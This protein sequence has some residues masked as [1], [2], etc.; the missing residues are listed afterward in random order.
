M[1]P[2]PSIATFTFNTRL[3]PKFSYKAQLSP[4]PA[5]LKD[6]E[7]KWACNVLKTPYGSLP[8][9]LV[10]YG[11]NM[12]FI[13]FLLLEFNLL[14][15]PLGLLGLLFKI[16]NFGMIFF[17]KKF[18][19]FLPCTCLPLHMTFSRLPSGILPPLL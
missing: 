18:L 7:L 5:S 12:D 8:P 17:L 9:S 2:P 19:F 14:L 4:P 15:L 3:V 13:N 10:N 1:V 6:D 11:K 16:G